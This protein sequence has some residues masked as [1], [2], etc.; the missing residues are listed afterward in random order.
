V[1][2]LGR[3]AITTPRALDLRAVQAAVE[4]ARQRVEALERYVLS[5]PVSSTQTTG[6]TTNAATNATLAALTA[7]IATQRSNLTALEARV[8][9]LEAEIAGLTTAGTD[10]VLYDDMGRAILANGQAILVI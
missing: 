2:T 1:S 5:L 3:P 4:G 9:A 7:E 6:S 8:T 10:A